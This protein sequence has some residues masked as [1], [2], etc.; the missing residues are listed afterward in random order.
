MASTVYAAP[1]VL[2]AWARGLSEEEAAARLSAEGWN[3]IP[4]AARRTTL[5]IALDVAREPMFVLLL[6][7]G[8]LYVLLGDLRE[9]LLLLGSVLVILAITLVQERRTERALEALRDLSSPRALVVRGGVQRRIAG[10]EVA[11][12]DLLVIAEGDRVAADALLVLASSDLSTDESLLTGESVPVG[13][14]AAASAVPLG[15]PGGDDTPFVY[16][17]TLA[18]RG[19]GVAVVA[20]TGAATEMGRIGRA[21]A[22]LET[23]RTPLQREI[24]RV[25]R[26]LAAGGGVLCA[27]VFLAFGLLH[28][29]WLDGLLAGITLAMAL[30]PEE[31]PVVLTVFL[32]LGAWRIARSRVLTRRVPAVEAL[33]AATV[34]C[35]DKTGTLTFNRMAVVALV[36]DDGAVA[37][38]DAEDAPLP[39]QLVPLARLAVRASLDVPFDPMEQALHRLGA[40][41]EDD[42]EP[43]ARPVRDYPLQPG[44]PAM[45]RVWLR[46]GAATAEV[47][48]KGAPEAVATLCGLDPEARARLDDTVAALADS[49]LRVIAIAAAEVPVAHIPSALDEVQALRMEGL[50][51]LADPV[52]PTVPAAIAECRRAGIRVV[53]ITG[54]HVATA[55]SIARTIGLDG[56]G[57]VL[58]GADID[59]MDDDSLGERAATVSVCARV[60]PEQKLRLVRALQARGEVVAMTGDG[61]NDAPALRAAHIGVAMGGRGADVARESAALVLLDDDFASIVVAVR[62]GRRIFDNLVKA[63]TYILAVHVPIAGLSLIPVLVGWP[64]MLL[65]LHI[66]FLELIID[67]SCSLVFEAE[68]A[69]PDVMDRPPRD[70]SRPL[71]SRHTVA[72]SVLQG[73]GVLAVTLALLATMQLRGFPEDETRAAVFLALV[74]ANLSLILANRSFS[75]TA[76]ALLRQRNAALRWVLAGAGALLALVLGLSGA[77]E[78]LR[79]ATL[80]WGEV[81]LAVALGAGSIAWVEVMKLLRG[82]AAHPAS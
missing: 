9:A 7:A 54:D 55:R 48:V 10:R 23:E 53:M 14:T 63:I 50:V 12:G 61:V 40:V 78:V 21:L 46:D 67:P 17:G 71:F 26:L 39:P 2:P 11:R 28:H 1:A 77:R 32:A 29:E 20:A 70:R 58:T 24:G 13:K 79:F 3:E 80:G 82:H 22:T 8:G 81:V 5:R 49:G 72:I 33:G 42:A 27:M 38:R 56:G 30:L 31:F 34:L 18:V 62:L 25:V 60:V 64:L 43:S 69:E 6:A 19:H 52:R 75:R 4:S 47:A 66:V 76:L 57:A 59:A 35:V 65:P 51:G 73:S 74:V 41:L 16:S 45:G 44:L 68:P 15:R 36:G 37:R